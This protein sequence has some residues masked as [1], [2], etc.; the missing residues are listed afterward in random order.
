MIHR[1]WS[2]PGK[3]KK[4]DSWEFAGD[5]VIG[6]ARFNV[7]VGV[8]CDLVLGQRGARCHCLQVIGLKTQGF[9]TNRETPA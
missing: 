3:A 9:L 6:C 4:T 7:D 2:N 1:I 8:P 5:R